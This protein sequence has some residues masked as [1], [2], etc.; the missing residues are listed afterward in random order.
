MR[1]LKKLNKPWIIIMLACLPFLVALTGESRYFEIAK[2]MSIYASLYKEV[3]QYYVDDINPNSVMEDGIKGMLGSLDPYTNYIP[4]DRIE[5]FRTQ[6]TGEYAGIG[7]STRRFDGRIF[8]SMVFEGFS[9]QKAGIKIGD[10]V[11]KINGVNLAGLTNEQIGRLLKGQSD[12]DLAVTVKR[13]GQSSPMDIQVNREKITIENVPYSGIVK[14]DVGYLKLTEF[15]PNASIN[16][17]SA[18]KDLKKEGA[19][20]LIIDLRNNPGGLLVEAVNISNLFLPKGYPIVST[21]GKIHENDTEYKA[22]FEPVD[23]NIPVAILINSRSASASEIVGGV[24]QDYDRG[25]LIGQKSYGKGLVQINRPLSYN[26]QLKVTTAKYY[27]PSGRCIQAIDYSHR[28]SDGS[29]GKVPDSLISEFKTENGRIVFD[30][31]GIDPD[32]EV[33]GETFPPIAAALNRQGLIFQYA[34]IYSSDKKEIAPAREFKISDEEY[35][36]FINWSKDQGFS[37]ETKM[38]ENLKELHETYK[39]DETLD[40]LNGDFK[41]MEDQIIQ[42]KEQDFFTHKLIIKKLLEREIIAHYYLESGEIQASFETDPFILAA[43]DVLNND[44][45]YDEILQ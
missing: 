27:I 43:L 13:Y 40:Q 32:L 39:D 42:A 12:S 24:F 4:E 1:F 33:D 8:V 23:V 37:F 35:T 15:T 25:V 5:D 28:R 6:N 3:I 26:S 9:A 20:K 34:T 44:E 14:G 19:E 21:K 10:E 45:K 2:N 22:M 30:G 38:E 11:I 17:K 36:E 18:L 7:V 31:G 16:I 41:K 29:V